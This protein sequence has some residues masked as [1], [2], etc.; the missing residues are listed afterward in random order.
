[1]S[2]PAVFELN[3]TIIKNNIFTI[4][5]NIG[6]AIHFH[7][8][9]VRFDLSIKEF[10]NISS[11]LINILNEQ[12]NIPSFDLNKQN[13][14]FLEKIASS[15][16]YIVNVM[17]EIVDINQLKYRFENLNKEIIDEKLISTPVYQYYLGNKEIISNYELKRDIW[18]SKEE[19][20]ESIKSNATTDIYIDEND[21]ILDG[22]K[23][24]CFSLTNKNYEKLIKVKRIIFAKNKIPN[25]I[26]KLEK[27]E[28]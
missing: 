23:T 10:N 9:L 8:G 28:W 17:D 12:L 13:E 1:M 6:E 24:L 5:D 7:I 11:K 27:K 16:P 4:E 22:Y 25:I 19:L 14:Y 2:N 20:L 15:I 26:L 21:Y 18:Q 3:K